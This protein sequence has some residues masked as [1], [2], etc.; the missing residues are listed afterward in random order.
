M[1]R[2]AIS[3]PR[4]RRRRRRS[5]PRQKD[6]LNPHF[7]SAYATLASILSACRGPLTKYGL[8]IVQSP[9]LIHAGDE[10]LVEV[11]TT[12]FHSSGQFLADTLSVPVPQIHAQSLGSALTYL[13][14]YSVLSFVGIAPGGED[15]DDGNQAVSAAAA[16]KR[17]PTEKPRAAS[18]ENIGGVRDTPPKTPRA[19]AA[20]ETITVKVIGIVKRLLTN[21][22]EKYLISGDDRNVYATF[23]Q[24]VAKDAK[25][26]QE[27]GRPI[28]ITFKT[29]AY[30]KDI[31]ALTEAP[32]PPL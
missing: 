31:T 1:N 12:L 11:E 18:A 7:G 32:V 27:A 16:R 14:R 26:A 20:A 24:S 30:G 19:P 22:R 13:R 3:S 28:A 21:G 8:S 4:S 23:S 17:A 5:A 15:D 10:W 6:A 9:R 2:S 29:T 25:A